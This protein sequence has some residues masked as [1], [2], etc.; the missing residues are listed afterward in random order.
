MMMTKMV[1]ETL[2]QYGHMTWMIAQDFIEFSLHKSSRTYNLVHVFRELVYD[3][4]IK[5]YFHNPDRFEF[6]YTPPSIL[7]VIVHKQKE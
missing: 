3:M 2:V 5:K 6:S 4:P 7:Y 1:L